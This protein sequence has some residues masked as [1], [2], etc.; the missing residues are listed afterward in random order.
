M[1]HMAS[2]FPGARI[3][4]VELDPH[5][6][7]LARHNIEPWSDRCEVINAA[8]WPED[9]EVRFNSHPRNEDGASVASEGRLTATAISLNSLHERTGSADFVKMDVEGGEAQLLTRQTAWAAEVGCLAVECH[10]PYSIEQG[11]YDL[12]ALGFSVYAL[13][14]SRRRRA[15]DCA[16]GVR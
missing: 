11:L 9:G 1:A 2:G 10:P 7:A 6:A 13:R 5:N 14:Q 4:G 12:R 3:V 8:V 15:R 16:V